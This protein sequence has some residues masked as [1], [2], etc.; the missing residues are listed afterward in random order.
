MPF[1]VNTNSNSMENIKIHT[2]HD[3][4]GMVYEKNDRIFRAIPA[5]RR[6][7]ILSLI[8]SDFFQSLMK[9]GYFP[10]T[11]ITDYKLC[12]YDFVLEH[13]RKLIIPP[14]FW[15]YSRFLDATIFLIYINEMSVK[16]GYCLWDGS[17]SNVGFD[18]G[19][20]F[21]FD[22]GAFENVKYYAN[23]IDIFFKN[24]YPMF[25]LF[26]GEEQSARFHLSFQMTDYANQFPSITRHRSLI[27]IYSYCLVICRKKLL[28]ALLTLFF[29]PFFILGGEKRRQEKYRKLKRKLLEIDFL[30][31]LR[32]DQKCKEDVFYEKVTHEIDNF[33]SAYSLIAE[34][35]ATYNPNSIIV[36]AN[37]PS[38]PVFLNKNGFQN[39]T[40]LYFNPDLNDTDLIYRVL[41]RNNINVDVYLAGFHDMNRT[42]SLC[43]KAD[44]AVCLDIA[45][46]LSQGWICLEGFLQTLSQYAIKCM[47]FNY[48]P[49]LDIS[50]R[51]EYIYN[52]ATSMFGSVSVMEH[53]GSFYFFI[54]KI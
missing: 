38:F 23:I 11:S 42:C 18:K 8:Y 50:D 2:L 17:W 51:S 6:E 34:K 7:Y 21:I 26:I 29:I 41:K 1:V 36:W 10:R 27:A 33:K 16:A 39:T 48:K 53:C 14:L 3:S 12:G 40:K 24:F 45:D 43:V 25:L 32:I 37:N 19:K 47:I 30:E 28:A 4:H 35:I 52:V 15:T 9:K 22:L 46:G 13:E 54:R 31:H 49:S 44:I 5:G 20:P